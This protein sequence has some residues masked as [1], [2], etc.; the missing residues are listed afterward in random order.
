M[1]KR[2]CK[3]YNI[4]VATIISTVCQNFRTLYS[5]ARLGMEIFKALANTK[6]NFTFT[7]EILSSCVFLLFRLQH[8][9]SASKLDIF[10][11]LGVCR[12]NTYHSAFFL[13]IWSLWYAYLEGGGRRC[14]G[15]LWTYASSFPG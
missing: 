8:L 3:Y 10:H 11:D 9:S 14:F 1:L 2:T 6:V 5:V 7:T 4:I 12:Q 13:L 15:D